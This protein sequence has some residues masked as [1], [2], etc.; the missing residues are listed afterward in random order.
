MYKKIVLVNDYIGHGIGT[1]NVLQPMLSSLGHTVSVLP[2]AVMSHSF[3]LGEYDYQALTPHFKRTLD[4]WRQLDFQFDIWM[5]GF[6]DCFDSFEQ[7]S[8]L[9]EELSRQRE[10][11]TFILVDPVLGEAGTLYPTLPVETIGEMRSL[12]P[13]ADL[14]TPNGTEAALLLQETYPLSREKQNTWLDQLQDLGAKSIVVTDV[15]GDTG[16]YGCIWYRDTAGKT[17]QVEF[18]KVVSAFSG[19]GDYFN[20][21][22]VGALCI[23]KNLGEAVEIAAQFLTIALQSTLAAG[24]THKDGLAGELLL[25]MYTEGLLHSSKNKKQSL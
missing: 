14:I 17:G 10:R 7:F 16:E 22:L 19:S 24:R 1:V 12:I 25:A 2:T 6:I 18:P 21:I 9:R 4:L 13:F 20:S 8:L 3:D 11:G 5:T 15:G 23:G